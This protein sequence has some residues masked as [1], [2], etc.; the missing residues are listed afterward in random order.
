MPEFGARQ[1]VARLLE[2]AHRHHDA[3]RV[4]TEGG[5]AYPAET[6]GELRRIDAP[7]DAAEVERLAKR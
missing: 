3:V 5:A 1:L 2:F 6:A 7:D 4:L